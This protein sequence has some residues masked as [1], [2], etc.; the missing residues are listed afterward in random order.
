MKRKTPFSPSYNEHSQKN[1]RIQRQ[2]TT[3]KVPWIGFNEM[4]LHLYN[5]FTTTTT[6][7]TTATAH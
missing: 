6:T 4:K 1:V 7:T 5:T 2:R 3:T